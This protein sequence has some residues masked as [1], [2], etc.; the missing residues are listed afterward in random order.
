MSADGPDQC[1]TFVAR[2]AAGVTSAAVPLHLLAPRP[3]T[4]VVGTPVYDAGTDSWSVTVG[5]VQNYAPVAEVRPG[6]CPGTTPTDLTWTDSPDFFFGQPG[7]NCLYVALA[8]FWFANWYGPVV[9]QGVHPAG[10]LTIPLA[11]AP[12]P[13]S[14]RCRRPS[15]G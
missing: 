1:V 3:P 8:D 5:P 2:S 13:R 12:A 9:K 7:P 11:A 14:T 4:P 6:S 15:R 10:R